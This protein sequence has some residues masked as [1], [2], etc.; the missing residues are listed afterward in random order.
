VLNQQQMRY[1]ALQICISFLCNF[2]TVYCSDILIA[3]RRCSSSND[4]PVSGPSP[5]RRGLPCSL[6]ACRKYRHIYLSL[7]QLASPVSRRIISTVSD[8]QSKSIESQAW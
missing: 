7:R 5:C 8:V 6:F 1:G 3:H 2:N 4:P